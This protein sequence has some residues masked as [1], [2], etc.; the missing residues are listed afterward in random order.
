MKALQHHPGEV[1]ALGAAVQL[2]PSPLIIL[3][4]ASVG[5]LTKYTVV[6]KP[7]PLLTVS[8]EE[9]PSSM[10]LYNNRKTKCGKE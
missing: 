4:S 1:V 9:S 2:W 10:I 8:H 7:D 6:L 5:N 3:I